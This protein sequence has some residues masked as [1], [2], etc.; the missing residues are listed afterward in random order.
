MNM[1]GLLAGSALGALVLVAGGAN[2]GTT[3]T[4]WTSGSTGFPGNA[5]GT[6]GGVTVTYVGE[7][8]CLNCFASNWSPASTWIGGPVTMPPPDNSG[9]Q[10]VGG[11]GVTDTVSFSS[12]VTNPVMAIVSLGQ[13]GLTASFN[14]ASN[15]PFVLLG[16]GPSSTW[17][18]EP[19]TSSGETVFGTEGNGLVEF[20]GTY[21]QITWTNPTFE[22]YYA[23]TVGTA[24]VPEPAAWAMLLIGLGAVGASLRLA[25]RTTVATA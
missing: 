23:F 18:G 22:D 11:F 9:I 4:N 25:R 17:G 21:S 8:T 3:W 10:L 5:S 14:F 19:L 1:K 7:N 2:A 24:G 16:G 13:P 15:E 20:I 6:M 12:P